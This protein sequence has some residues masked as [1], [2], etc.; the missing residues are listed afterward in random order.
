MTKKQGDA[1]VVTQRH[2]ETLPSLQF[3]R[4]TA[5]DFDFKAAGLHKSIFCIAQFESFTLHTTYKHRGLKTHKTNPL[6]NKG[7]AYKRI[8]AKGI[9]YMTTSAFIL[10]FLSNSSLHYFFSISMYVHRYSAYFPWPLI[11]KSSALCGKILS[12]HE[13]FIFFKLRCF[14]T[15]NFYSK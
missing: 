3:Y 2:N 12:Y 13:V 9:Q 7:W 8:P 4:L 14:Y 10:C 6:M 15:I 11:K 5:F 1:K